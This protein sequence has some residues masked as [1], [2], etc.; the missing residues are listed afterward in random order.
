MQLPDQADGRAPHA[1]DRDVHR[2][3]SALTM[4]QALAARSADVLACD[5]NDELTSIGRRILGR[6]GVAHRIDLGSPRP[7]T[8]S[9]AA[10][11]RPG[12][13]GSFDSAFIDADK[14]DYD[15][16]YEACLRLLRP[17]GLI[18]IDNTSCGAAGSP[19]PRIRVWIRTPRPCAGSTSSCI[20]TSGW[21]W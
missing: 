15:G 2:L 3:F 17:G 1:R 18:A 8:P 16:Y 20:W 5:V 4:A 10:R 21:I 11:G 6:A 12:R 19:G 13:D 9:T 7:W 14:T